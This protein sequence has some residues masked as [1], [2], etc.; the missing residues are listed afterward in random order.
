[1]MKKSS[2][3]P[4]LS[5]VKNPKLDTKPPITKER[6]TS[7]KSIA[8]QSRTVKAAPIDDRIKKQFQL[9]ASS[10]SDHDNDVANPMSRILENSIHEV[11]DLKYV[12][13]GNLEIAAILEFPLTAY[14]TIQYLVK[15]LNLLIP[16]QTI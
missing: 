7:S 8:K 13:I 11:G 14:H 4:P 3:Q 15:Q 12:V 2:L 6:K 10:V 5:H 1:M 9:P 16:D